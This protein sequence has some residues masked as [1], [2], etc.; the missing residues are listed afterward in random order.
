[1]GRGV[2]RE[3]WISLTFVLSSC[4]IGSTYIQSYNSERLIWVVSRYGHIHIPPNLDSSSDL[5]KHNECCCIASCFIVHMSLPHTGACTRAKN[6]LLIMDC[7]QLDPKAAVTLL[8]NHIKLPS[9]ALK[10]LALPGTGLGAPSSFKLGILA[11]ASIGLSALSAALVYS[12]V[13]NTA[14]P[15]VEVPPQRAVV[16]FDSS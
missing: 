2:V 12:H 14:V 7:T 16:E 9:S 8:W 3:I 11:Q 6:L 10:S 5:G 4:E 13:N 15:K 1:V